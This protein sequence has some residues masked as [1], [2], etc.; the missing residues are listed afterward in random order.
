M[1]LYG[2]HVTP[3]QAMTHL[4]FS[5]I[6]L[7]WT[8]GSVRIH[9]L[10]GDSGCVGYA[11]LGYCEV[12]GHANWMQGDKKGC[13]ITALVARMLPAGSVRA[14]RQGRAQGF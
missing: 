11:I 13:I 1:P 3:R 8:E 10:H 7:S 9:G 12:G 5:Q 4:T 2:Q 14:T 6:E